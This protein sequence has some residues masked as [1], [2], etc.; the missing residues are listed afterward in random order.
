MGL[1]KD[2]V[3]LNMLASA[4]TSYQDGVTSRVDREVGERVLQLVGGTV[5]WRDG[6]KGSRFLHAKCRAGAAAR[7]GTFQPH[8]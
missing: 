3:V 1:G 6:G 7:T 8:L 4:L 2:Q 5:G